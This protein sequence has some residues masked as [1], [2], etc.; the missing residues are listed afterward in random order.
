MSPVAILILSLSMSADA[1]AAALARGASTRPGWS[2]ALR[3]GLVFDGSGTAPYVGDIGLRDG[4]IAAIGQIT[5]RGAEEIDAS[6]R[7]DHDALLRIITPRDEEGLEI[8]RHSSAHLV[9]HADQVVAALHAGEVF[10]W[11][12]DVMTWARERPEGQ[13]SPDGVPA[14]L[15][16][17]RQPGSVQTVFPEPDVRPSACR[18]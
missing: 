13:S 2:A 9:G 10:E 4:K 17:E 16:V 12:H 7:I 15:Q 8:I 5:G 6:D 11:P 3:G 1:F 14:A 18:K